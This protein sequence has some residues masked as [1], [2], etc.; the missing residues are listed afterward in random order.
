MMMTLRVEHFAGNPNPI[1]SR[2]CSIY[3]VAQKVV[4]QTHGDEWWLRQFLTDFQ[5]SFTAGKRSDRISNETHILTM[6]HQL[7][8]CVGSRFVGTPTSFLTH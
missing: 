6:E 1:A 4:H 2:R 3:T 8:H 7:V 5:N